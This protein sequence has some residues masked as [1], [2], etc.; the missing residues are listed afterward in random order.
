MDR[1]AIGWIAAAIVGLVFLDLVFVELRRAVREGTRIV[2]RLGSYGDL[3]IVSLLPGAADDA[4]RLARALDAVPL[5]L[6]RAEAALAVIRNPFGAPAPAR[7]SYSP[8]GSSRSD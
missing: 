1:G 2:R 5:L 3:P 8:N 4:E 7:G 6:A